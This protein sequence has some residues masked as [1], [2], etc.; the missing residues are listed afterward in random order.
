MKRRLTIINRSKFKT[1][2]IE[3][4]ILGLLAGQEAPSFYLICEDV[5]SCKGIALTNLDKP[6]IIIFIQDLGQFAKTFVHELTHI[7]QQAKGYQ[8]EDE[9]KQKEREIVID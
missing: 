9:A 1:K 6:T 2:D 4:I 8:N 3:E 7:Q 5:F